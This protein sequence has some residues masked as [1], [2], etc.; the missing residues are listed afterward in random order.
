M[1]AVHS[2]LQPPRHESPSLYRPVLSTLKAI[3]GLFLL[4]QA[5]FPEGHEHFP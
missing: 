3:D 5:H 2:F 1:A 4:L